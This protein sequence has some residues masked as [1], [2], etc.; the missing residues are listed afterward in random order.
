[1]RI[2]EIAVE[3]DGRRLA[4]SLA[5]PDRAEDLSREPAVLLSFSATRQVTLQTQPYDITARAFVEAGHYALSFDLPNHGERA[6]EYG[7]GLHGMYAAYAAGD[8]PFAMFVADGCAA[9]DACLEQGLATAGRVFSCGVSRAGYCALRLAAAE[10]RISGVTALA[11]VVDW[12]SLIEFSS[13]ANASEIEALRLD[14]WAD[15]LAGRAIF[16]AIGNH[17]HRVGTDYCARFAQSLFEAEDCRAPGTSSC[18]V[19]IVDSVGHVL[20]DEWARAGAQFLLNLCN[21]SRCHEAN[22]RN[23]RI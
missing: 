6:N 23:E 21:Q 10:P 19:H 9:V 17:D 15:R 1:M 8:D 16:V 2:S 12:R 3:V 22:Q 7:E 4:C 14:H 5:A 18:Q 20:P 13:I 11:P